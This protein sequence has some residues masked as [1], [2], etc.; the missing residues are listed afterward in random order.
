MGRAWHRERARAADGH[1]AA[2]VRAQDGPI[3]LWRSSERPPMGSRWGP[4]EIKECQ[5]RCSRGGSQGWVV[6]GTDQGRFPIGVVL[7]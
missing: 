6:V 5:H 2:L 4:A 3:T 1:V 7:S